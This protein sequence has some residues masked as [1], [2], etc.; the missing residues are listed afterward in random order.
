MYIQFV[1]HTLLQYLLQSVEIGRFDLLVGAIHQHKDEW[2]SATLTDGAV[3]VMIHGMFWTPQ[4]P[5]T[6]LDIVH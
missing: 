6:S 1:I 2:K 4:L 5:V 3:F